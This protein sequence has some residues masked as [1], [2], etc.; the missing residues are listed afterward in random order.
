MPRLAVSGLRAVQDPVGLDYWIW[1]GRCA[2]RESRP[3][4]WLSR[5]E[6]AWQAAGILLQRQQL[7]V[8]QRRQP[9]RPELDRADRENP[10]GGTAGSTVSWPAWE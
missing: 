7:T 10:D 8:L 5:R 2:C 9:R 6:E 4:L 3:Q 1:R